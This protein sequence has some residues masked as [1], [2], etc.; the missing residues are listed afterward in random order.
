MNTKRPMSFEVPIM[1]NP[2]EFLSVNNT[3]QYS[4]DGNLDLHLQAIVE[5][6]GKNENVDKACQTDKFHEGGK[7]SNKMQFEIFK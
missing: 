4:T 3:S 2:G 5:A 7:A 6:D 1:L